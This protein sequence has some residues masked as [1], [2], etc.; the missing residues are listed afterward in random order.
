MST[1]AKDYKKILLTNSNKICSSLLN[2]LI[3]FC[4]NKCRFCLDSRYDYRSEIENPAT[5]TLGSQIKHKT[6]N[7]IY[8]KTSERTRK[9]AE[10][11]RSFL[12]PRVDKILTFERETLLHDQIHDK[13]KK[14]KTQ[15]PQATIKILLWPIRV[16]WM[17]LQKMKKTL[18]IWIDF[19]FYSGI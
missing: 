11:E 9:P 5:K 8:L 1:C 3:N 13:R 10:K 4:W 6:L 18:Y 16:P 14:P 7:K 12:V 2:L 15:K 17:W 19:N